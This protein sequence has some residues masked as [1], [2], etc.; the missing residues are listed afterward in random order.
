[1]QLARTA[2]LG[3]LALIGSVAKADTWTDPATT[4]TWSYEWCDGGCRVSG[5]DH[6][7]GQ[8]EIPSVISGIVVREIKGESFFACSSITSVK[9]P[10]TLRTIHGGAFAQCDGITSLEIPW[11]VSEFGRG[12]FSGCSS[13]VSIT[14]Q[15]GNT[16][17]IAEDDCLLSAD[18]KKVHLI[19]CGK[20]EVVIPSSVVTVCGTL[21]YG[22]ERT[23][24][25]TLPDGVR[26]VE[27]CAFANSGLKRLVFNGDAPSSV[28]IRVLDDTSDDLIVSVPVGSTGWPSDGF[29]CGKKLVVRDVEEYLTTC[30]TNTWH[31]AEGRL[32]MDS[33]HTQDELRT[34]RLVCDGDGNHRVDDDTI[35]SSHVLT[36]YDE[37]GNVTSTSVNCGTTMVERIYWD[38]IRL[39]LTVTHGEGSG[40]EAGVPFGARDV[41]VEQFNNQGLITNDVLHAES[42]YGTTSE[43]EEH[44]GDLRYDEMGNEIWC[45][46]ADTFTYFGY[47]DI[48]DLVVS[49]TTVLSADISCWGC[50]G[51]SM[52]EE[53]I[54]GDGTS[55]TSVNIDGVL[56]DGMGR[57]EEDWHCH[58]TTNRLGYISWE[59]RH[60]MLRYD[61]DDPSQEVWL[62]EEFRNLENGREAVTLW[63]WDWVDAG[64]KLKQSD[65]W[66]CCPFEDKAGCSVVQSGEPAIVLADS[67]EEAIDK[68]IVKYSLPID[69]WGNPVM[70]CHEYRRYFSIAAEEVSTGT[71]LVS[72]GLDSE[73]IGLS[74]SVEALGLCLGEI[75]VGTAESIVLPASDGLC[76]SLLYTNDLASPMVEGERVMALWGTVELPLPPKEEGCFFKVKVSEGSS[77]EV[78]E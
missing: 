38:Q 62:S 23:T 8:L 5:C 40:C 21:L 65:A 50:S 35:I 34:R 66:E 32:I 49:R 53:T 25:I 4:I 47:D 15:N 69:E 63:E 37:N 61:A 45:K 2:F 36:E 73:K 42:F 67:A 68:T 12:A 78:E 14:V 44:T 18:G 39:K 43:I 11:R 26:S 16:S 9:L 30:K 71:W 76:Y 51:N 60:G 57:V 54:Y 29:W 58:E 64:W 13:L 77:K 1:M 41:H 70:M 6:C 74:D 22:S 27:D 20:A 31:D 19:P 3:L 46:W 48:S 72:V 10:E 17:F 24:D 56:F 59:K 28:G 7:F 55:E 75:A 33:V 52:V